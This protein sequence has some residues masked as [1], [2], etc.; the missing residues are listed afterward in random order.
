[1]PIRLVLGERPHALVGDEFQQVMHGALA[2]G[3]IDDGAHLLPVEEGAVL[4][5]LGREQRGKDEHGERG[6]K[7]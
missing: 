7:S 2:R 6:A 5:L 1:M 4:G 3:L